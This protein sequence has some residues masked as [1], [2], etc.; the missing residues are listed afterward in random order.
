VIRSQRLRLMVA[1]LA[2]A[3][4]SRVRRVLLTVGLGYEI[5]SDARVGRSII[6]VDKLVMGSGASIGSL[7]LIRQC[8]RVELGEQA[9]I[10]FLVWVNSVARSKGYFDGQRRELRL[11]LGDRA[12]IT[13]LHLVDCC[14]HVDIGALSTVAGFGSQI[15]THSIDVAEGRQVARP[16]RIGER[17]FVGTGAVIVGGAVVADRAVVGAGS[18]VHG[19][20]AEESTLYAGVPAIR[21]RSL[22]PSSRYFTR[23]EA[24][25]R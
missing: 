21:R 3:A 12:V 7:C 24:L 8:E 5:A 16:V 2:A 14:D 6:A 4:P 15:L 20:L 1:V 22:D 11:T 25:V 19:H 13:C 9:R 23:A 10:G 18:V 17:V